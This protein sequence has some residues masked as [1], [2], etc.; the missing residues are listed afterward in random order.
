MSNVVQKILVV[1]VCSPFLVVG[2]VAFMHV[3]NGSRHWFD[4]LVCGT[5]FLVFGSACIGYIWRRLDRVSAQ[6]SSSHA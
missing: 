1:L 3:L 2:V 6:R 5:Y 4:S